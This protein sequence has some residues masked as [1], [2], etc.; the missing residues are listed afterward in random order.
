MNAP[1]SHSTV[2]QRPFVTGDAIP[3]GFGIIVRSYEAAFNKLTHPTG[4]FP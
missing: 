2:I 3:F 4:F 1:V